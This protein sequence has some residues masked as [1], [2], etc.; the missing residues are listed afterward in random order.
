MARENL[1]GATKSLSATVYPGVWVGTRGK[2]P[3]LPRP[4]WR[5]PEPRD[6]LGAGLSTFPEYLRVGGKLGKSVS[7]VCETMEY[8]IKSI[9]TGTTYLTRGKSRTILHSLHLRVRS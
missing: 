5:V 4:S 3:R 9:P 1:V 6:A 8:G 7:A 2:H